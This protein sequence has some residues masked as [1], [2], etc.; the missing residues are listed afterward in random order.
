MSLQSSREF[1]DH[2][3]KK[4]S[5]QEL[6]EILEKHMLF[7]NGRTGGERATLSMFDLSYLDLSGRNLARIECAGTLFCHCDLSD[8]NL[9]GAVLFAADMRYTNLQRVKLDKSDIR[10]ACLAGSDLTGASL[11]DADMR[12]GV[13]LK[14]KKGGGDLIPVVH[15]DATGGF[16]KATIRGADMTGAKVSDSMIVQTDM[17]DCILRNAKFIRTNLSLSNLTGCDLEG[18]DFTDANL[19][20]A[21]F[22]GA[23]FNHTNLSNADLSGADLVGAIF[24]NMDLTKVNL[25]VAYLAKRVEDLD[26]SLQEIV[27]LHARWVDSNGSD[28]ARAVF[29]KTDLTGKDLSGVNLAASDM[30][31]AILQKVNFSRSELL[32]ADLSFAD[33]RGAEMARSDLRGIKLTRANLVGANMVGALLGEVVISTKAQ[34]GKVRANLDHAILRDAKLNGADLRNADLE[35]TDLRNADL[36]DADLRGASLLDADLTGA[37]LRGA[38]LAGID[39]RGAV[40]LPDAAGHE[41][42]VID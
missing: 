26:I 37:D 17:T 38:Q 9:E 20:G 36:R 7:A 10:G 1:G 27:L 15:E 12:D 31:F 42:A 35:A 13:L 14:P 8:A 2:Q 29:S 19:S 11:V 16:E 41:D 30:S 32:M 34:G 25:D 39:K 21:I 40:G 5:Q 6:D 4:I 33:L 3:W 22:H 23:V 24:D 28:G 18:A